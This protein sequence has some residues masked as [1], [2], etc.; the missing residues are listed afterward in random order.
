LPRGEFPYQGWE[1]KKNQKRLSRGSGNWEKGNHFWAFGV[2][3][4]GGKETAEHGPPRTKKNILKAGG[5][6]ARV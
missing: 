2:F 4:T 6:P 1:K 5:G 3:K